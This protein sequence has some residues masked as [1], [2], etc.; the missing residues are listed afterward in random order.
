MNH[1][2]VIVLWNIYMPMPLVLSLTWEL[3]DLLWKLALCVMLLNVMLHSDVN[4]HL[5][6]CSGLSCVLFCL[7]HFV[8]LWTFTDHVSW[9]TR[10]LVHFTLLK[11]VGTSLSHLIVVNNSSSS[12]ICI[13]ATFLC[14]SSSF[15]VPW[16]YAK[17][18]RYI[19][20]WEN[21]AR[22]FLLLLS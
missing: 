12:P 5:L 22:N 20:H 16:E 3:V 6:G 9:E 7:H 2:R 11:Q 15:S 21:Y 1:W 17:A 13:A 18:Q 8:S 14:F 4:S 10:N 19:V